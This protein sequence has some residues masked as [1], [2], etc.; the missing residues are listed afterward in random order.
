MALHG[1]EDLA[2]A[3]GL[4]Y[5]VEAFKTTITKHRFLA[6]AATMD[7]L[8]VLDHER[9]E[10]G[11]RVRPVE[12]EWYMLEREWGPM[13]EARTRGKLGSMCTIPAS[14]IVAVI[15]LSAGCD[16][17]VNGD[18]KVVIDQQW[19]GGVPEHPM[20]DRLIGIWD[21]GGAPAFEFVGDTD[22]GVQAVK[23]GDGPWRQVINH[24]RWEGDVLKCDSYMYYEEPH[25]YN[26]VL[27]QVSIQLGDD[28]DRMEYSIRAPALN[29]E[30]AGWLTR[31]K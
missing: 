8:F 9:G 24:M 2:A 16:R 29:S 21:D 1:H 18:S 3:P 6:E 11:R 31:H 22:G 13:E 4:Y 28:P 14:A 30:E 23:I 20:R 12:H 19:A 10:A 26:G 25:P 27:N 15:V 7:G 17:P 5:D